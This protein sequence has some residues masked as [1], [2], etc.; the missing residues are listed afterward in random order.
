MP[1]SSTRIFSPEVIY[2]NMFTYSSVLRACHGLPNLRQLHSWIIKSGLDSDV[3]VQSALID[4]YSKWGG[5]HN[6]L[7]VFDEMV[8][9]DSIVSNSIIG[10]FCSDH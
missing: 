6:A 5:S 3:F 4:I 9:G 7:S 8:T 1:G 2:P 10:G